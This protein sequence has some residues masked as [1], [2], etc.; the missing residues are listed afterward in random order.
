MEKGGTGVSAEDVLASMPMTGKQKRHEK[1]IKQVARDERK[2]SRRAKKLGKEEGEF[3][4]AP[5]AVDSDGEDD[6][7]L[8]NLSRDVRVH[9]LVTFWT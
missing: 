7:Q 9:Q 6:D 8:R 4:L 3:E 2:Q 1:R 5:P